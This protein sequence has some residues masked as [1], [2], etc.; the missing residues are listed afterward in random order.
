[1]KNNALVRIILF[2]VLTVV[3]CGILLIL[4][5][6]PRETTE[7]SSTTGPAVQTVPDQPSAA[8]TIPASQPT[9]ETTVPAETGVAEKNSASVP[10]DRIQ[11]IHI[12]WV[13]GSI[14]LTPGDTDQIMF[15][16][17]YRPDRTMVWEVSGNQLNI[18]YA[19]YKQVA[20]DRL[21]P[22]NYKKDL[23]ITVPRSWI[24][25]EVE[26][27]AAAADVRMSDLQ[28]GEVDINCVS[29]KSDLENCQ[30][31]EV[32]L[33]TVSGNVFFSGSLEE[34]DCDAVSADCTLKLNN[35][36]REIDLSSVSGAL[37]LT[38]PENSGFQVEME[39]KTG[40]IDTDFEVTGGRGSYRCGDGSCRIE[41]GSLT[42]RVSI[43]KA[44]PA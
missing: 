15:E 40:K 9:A 16:E 18:Q 6:A 3:L 33:N 19:D 43:R 21:S 2:A 38:L 29:G 5:L 4:F 27:N 10:A 12:D 35:T 26:I 30:A 1:M 34:L 28:V 13:A 17:T 44:G 7:L 8:T 39:G 37:D 42:S 20:F 41:I 11:E 32:S 31:R 22:K 14:T 23:T 25:R 24:G 36:P